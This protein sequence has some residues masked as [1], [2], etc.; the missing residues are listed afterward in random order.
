MTGIV[1]IWADP[2]GISAE[3]LHEFYGMDQ[4]GQVIVEAAPYCHL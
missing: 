3:I 2:R 1:I 4:K